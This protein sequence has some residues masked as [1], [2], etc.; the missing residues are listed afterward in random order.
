[1]PHRALVITFN[2]EEKRFRVV[3]VP[4]YGEKGFYRQGVSFDAFKNRE[5]KKLYNWLHVRKRK[6]SDL[7]WC[8]VKY[9]HDLFD[10]DF[11][12]YTNHQTWEDLPVSTS[13]WQFYK[14]IGYDYKKK[15]FLA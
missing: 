5:A 11:E 13:V 12:I 7:K 15:R 1:M 2:K 4:S 3:L 6:L 10:G 9:E 8:S 14:D